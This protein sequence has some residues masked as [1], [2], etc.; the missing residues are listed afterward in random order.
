MT[1]NNADAR[2]DITTI[3]TYIYIGRYVVPNNDDIN[4]TIIVS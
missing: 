1:D 2:L 4:I 3:G